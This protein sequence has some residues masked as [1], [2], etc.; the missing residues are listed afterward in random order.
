MST[1]EASSA[2]SSS[3]TAGTPGTPCWFQIPA[4]DVSRAK[5]FYAT[6]FDW[7]FSTPPDYPASEMALFNFPGP[8][9]KLGGGIVRLD[10]VATVEKP[11]G[12]DYEGENKVTMFF[13]CDDVEKRLEK[14][15]EAGGRV[16]RGKEKE[17]G[18]G[19][20][21]TF[22]DTEGNVQGLYSL[23]SAST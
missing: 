19:W 23:Q 8:N 6:V 21:A 16:V 11:V 18:H 12:Q 14:I 20:R 9:I 13:W 10:K 22:G 3:S 7:T 2:S 1:Q 15:V 5:A 17:G 4:L